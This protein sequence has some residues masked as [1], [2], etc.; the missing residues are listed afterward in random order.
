MLL[1]Q[2]SR[3]KLIKK[4]EKLILITNELNGKRT[5]TRIYG[6]SNSFSPS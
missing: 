6:Y 2:S 4:I 3:K 1:I 5:N